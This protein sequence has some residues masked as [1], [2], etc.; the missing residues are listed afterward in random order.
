M[1]REG[2][3]VKKKKGK[4]EIAAGAKGADGKR[5]L[6]TLDSSPACA[7]M[8]ALPGSV[9]RMMRPAP[10]QNY[11]RTGFPLEGKGARARFASLRRELQVLGEVAISGAGWRQQGGPL[12]SRVQVRAQDPGSFWHP[13]PGLRGLHGP[14]ASASQ[15]PR[16]QPFLSGLNSEYIPAPRKFWVLV[17]F[18]SFHYFPILC[19]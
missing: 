15:A 12:L 3:E 6:P 5:F 8:A 9:P 18:S 13:R 10:G 4:K 11:P 2:G 17:N 19:P 16:L 7:R 1:W 14:A